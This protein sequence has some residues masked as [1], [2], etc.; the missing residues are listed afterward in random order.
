MRHNIL[1]IT[2]LTTLT[3]AAAAC[4]TTGPTAT[5]A[6][7][8]QQ[9]FSSIQASKYDGTLAAMQRTAEDPVC[10]QFYGNA[11]QY[12]ARNKSSGGGSGIIKTVGLGILAGVASGGVSAIG[13]GS[14]FIETAVAST[15]N[16][17]VF[18][19][20]QKILSD[21]AG[22]K[23]ADPMLNVSASAERLGCPAL[24]KASLKASKKAMKSLKKNAAKKLKNEKE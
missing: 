3:F 22:P 5:S 9:L 6:T 2:A 18:Q 19:G 10:L 24:T 14:A 23:T 17:I 1:K 11:A 20:G 8:Q 21:T 13:I 7:P 16:Q 12:L 4:Q 15:A